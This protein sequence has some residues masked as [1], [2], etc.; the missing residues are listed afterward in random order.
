M[1]END[2]AGGRVVLAVQRAIRGECAELSPPK[3]RPSSVKSQEGLNVYLAGFAFFMLT[4][5]ADRGS[6]IGFGGRR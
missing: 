3:T 5:W 4:T 6:S 1:A 2:H